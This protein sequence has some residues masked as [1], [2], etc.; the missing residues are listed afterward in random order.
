MAEEVGF[1]ELAC[2]MKITPNT[3]LEK[4]GSAINASIF[5]ASNIAGTLKQDGLIDFTAYYPGPNEIQVT[6]KGKALLTEAD[7]KSTEPFDKLDEAILNQLSGGKRVPMDLQNTLNIRP[8]DLALR[9]YKLNKQNF[10]IYELRSGSV[11][12]MLTETGFL[13]A[14]ATHG[15]KPQ[16]ATPGAQPAPNAATSQPQQPQA[17]TAQQAA[18]PQQQAQ[19]KPQEQNVNE[20]L[21][22]IHTQRRATSKNTTIIAAF[23]LVVILVIVYYLVFVAQLITF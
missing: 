7:S 21:A 4:F 19:Q 15:Q 17:N 13:K 3:V 9:L 16:G 14:S 8:K 10:I 2:L 18:A 23:V 22:K 11:D 20:I 1:L 12:I 6:D 5:D